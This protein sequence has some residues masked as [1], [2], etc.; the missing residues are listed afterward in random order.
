VEAAGWGPQRPG[1]DC[2]SFCSIPDELST[3]SHLTEMDRIG[4]HRHLIYLKMVVLFGAPDS[5]SMV[6]DRYFKM[7][8]ACHALRERC[9]FQRDAEGQVMLDMS[10]VV[11]WMQDLHKWH[12][13]RYRDSGRCAEES[14]ARGTVEEDASKC[15]E[16]FVIS[17]VESYLIQELGLIDVTDDLRAMQKGVWMH[18]RQDDPGG[19]PGDIPVV[20][21]EELAQHFE[22]IRRTQ[23]GA[24][25]R[26][27]YSDGERLALGP[28]EVAR[29]L[30]Q[31]SSMRKPTSGGATEISNHEIFDAETDA[32]SDLVEIANLRCGVEDIRH[33]LKSLQEQ[34]EPGSVRCA[35][36]EEGLFTRVVQPGELAGVARDLNLP[37]STLRDL[38]KSVVDDVKRQLAAGP[39]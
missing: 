10:I 3:A 31:L 22:L 12:S 5:R 35:M 8:S 29:G 26:V 33:A 2:L 13:S 39:S 28:K 30:E 18:Y 15:P 11:S 37:E 20:V 1:V 25:R 23:D 17:M 4:I 16:R 21:Q 24:E 9:V 27:M 34:A 32:S 19:D 36:L 38:R 14:V 7:T 6:E